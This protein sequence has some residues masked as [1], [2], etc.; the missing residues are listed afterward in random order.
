MSMNMQMSAENKIA[1]NRQ[2]KKRISHRI[3]D[4]KVLISVRDFFL[5]IKY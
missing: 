2:D 4:I 5:K 3:S 1:I